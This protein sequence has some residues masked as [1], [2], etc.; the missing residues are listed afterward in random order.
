MKVFILT[1]LEGPAGVNGRSDAVVGNTMLNKPTAEQA[2]VNEVNAVCEGLIAAGA[3]EIVVLDGHGGSNSM[4]IF[5]LHPKAQLMQVGE[6]GPVCFMDGTYDA[7]IQLGAHGM[8]S[9]GSYMCHTFNSHGVT[10]MRLN[11]ELIGEI[12]VTSYLA[13]YFKVPTI[14]VSGDDVACHEAR[15][16]LGDALEVVPTKATINRY[17]AVNYPL[18]EVYANLRKTA[19]RALR[20][21]DKARCLEMPEYCE[22][23]ASVM[24]PNQ[25]GRFIRQGIEQV[26]DLTVR[27]TGDDFMEIWAQRLGWA[28]GVHK[29]R[30]NVTPEWLHPHTLARRAFND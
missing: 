12:G 4:N 17:A 13:A 18:E 20:N 23:T 14:M 10:E 28:P 9:S 5:N 2:L 22:F 7:F 27:Y 16:L 24:C 15:A 19:E 30:F 25:M 8:Q 1:D 26:D 6:W 11:G 3:N 29:K 21:L